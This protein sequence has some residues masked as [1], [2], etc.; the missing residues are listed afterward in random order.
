MMV[1]MAVVVRTGRILDLSAAWLAMMPTT[2]LAEHNTTPQVARELGKLLRQWHRLVKV[3]QD[4]TDRR[5]FC[6]G[7]PH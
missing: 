4:S 5:A 6:H 7:S 1:R 3:G 2:G